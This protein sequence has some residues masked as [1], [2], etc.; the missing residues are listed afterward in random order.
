MNDIPPYP[1]ETNASPMEYRRQLYA[2][3]KQHRDCPGFLCKHDNGKPCPQPP[4]I[5]TWESCPIVSVVDKR[6][7]DCGGCDNCIEGETHHCHLTGYDRWCTDERD[8]PVNAITA[9][10]DYALIVRVT[11][12]TDRISENDEES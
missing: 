4:S 11:Y 3:H 12:L 6:L 8:L 10:A 1:T 7:A 2:W 5:P 9:W